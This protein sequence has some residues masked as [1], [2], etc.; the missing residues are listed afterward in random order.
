MSTSIN[1]HDAWLACLYWF[2]RHYDMPRHP[3]QLLQALPLQRGCL[4]EAQL[5]S[6]AEN[7]GFDVC[8]AKLGAGGVGARPPLPAVAIDTAGRPLILLKF[9]AEQFEICRPEF[10]DGEQL[11]AGEELHSFISLDELDG[12]LF[13]LAPEQLSDARSRDLVQSKERHWLINAIAEVKPW[14]RDFL[15]ASLCINFIALIVPLFTMNVYDRVVP[16]QALHTLW[17][18]ALAAAIALSF[19]WLLKQARSR[20]ADMAGRSIELNISSKLMASTLGMRLANRPKSAA[21]FAKQIQEFDSVREFLTSATVACFVDLPF[22][23][24]FLVV[25]AWLGGPMVLVPLLAM[26]LIIT[27]SFLLRPQLQASI[28]QASQL[29]TQRQSLLI[30][31]LQLLP[32]SKQ[33][34]AEA[35]ALNRWQQTVAALNDWNTAAR[36]QSQKLSHSILSCQQFVT[37]GLIIWG[38]YR[39]GDG[40]LSMGGLIAIVML[41]GRAAASINQ[42]SMLLLKYQQT[43][44]AINSVEQ[45]MHLPQEG[46]AKQAMQNRQFNGNVSLKNV[47]FSY[48]NSEICVLQT[49][50]FSVARGER[51]ALIGA[52]GSGKSSL[53]SLLAGQYQVERGQVLFDGIDLRQW[54]LA[55]LRKQSAFL[56]Q[57]PALKYGSVLDNIV[58]GQEQVDAQL[59]KHVLYQSGLNRFVDQLPQGL[60]TCV[61]EL[62]RNLSGGQRQSV[63]LARALLREAP[64]LLLDEPTSAMDEKMQQQV[65]SCLQKLPRNQSLLVASHNRE[66]LELCDRAIVLERGHI[67][68]DGPVA[69]LLKQQQRVRSVAVKPVGK[70]E[71]KAAV[72]PEEQFNAQENQQNNSQINSLRPKYSQIHSV[73]KESAGSVAEV[74]SA[75]QHLEE[76]CNDN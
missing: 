10:D 26:L 17:V 8:V 4:S 42:L 14:Y 62:G 19:D 1:Q 47:D 70:P 3:A 41:S 74:V 69:Q 59:L 58:W 50:N 20:L 28:E 11:L 2:C 46:S 12:R 35:Q 9:K 61:G 71:V 65:I 53:L 57:Q 5:P 22:S 34:N 38:V 37:V 54:P 21:A 52:A 25:I 43:T 48:P 55:E 40:L 31:Q 60:D 6:A 18:L 64:L 13:L 51:I 72:K 49:I 29:S 24:L 66:V 15:L 16:N 7:A 73:K 68:A 30:E 45:V 56:A 33:L 76:G 75:Q 27:A 36:Q 63:V 32:E 39:I 23:L 44:T 67:V